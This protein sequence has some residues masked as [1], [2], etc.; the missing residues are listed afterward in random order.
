ME[1]VLSKLLVEHMVPYKFVTLTR[2]PPVKT[3]AHIPLPVLV[4][5][6]VRARKN[7]YVHVALSLFLPMH[8][9]PYYC[10]FVDFKTVLGLIHTRHFGTQYCDIA[11]KRYCDKKIFLSHG[12]L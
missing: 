1:K 11:I 7:T 6:P 12:S 10:F 2:R 5:I 3:P 4:V 9:D 8:M